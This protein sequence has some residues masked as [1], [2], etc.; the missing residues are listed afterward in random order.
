MQQLC[1]QM[2]FAR[3]HFLEVMAGIGKLG[4]QHLGKDTLY[5]LLNSEELETQSEMQVLQVRNASSLLWY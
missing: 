3:G 4:L 5:E 1:M 2:E